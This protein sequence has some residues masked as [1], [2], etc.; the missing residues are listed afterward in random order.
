MRWQGC[1][2]I[3]GQIKLNTLLL[4]TGM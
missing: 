2:V 4:F 3:S 1:F